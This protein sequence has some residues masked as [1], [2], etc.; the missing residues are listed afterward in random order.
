M[1]FSLLVL[2]ACLIAFCY[3]ANEGTTKKVVATTKKASSSGGGGGHSSGGGGH[4]SGG[5]A[6]S[7]LTQ[8]GDG[9]LTQLCG[10]Q[11]FAS[12]ITHCDSNS[13]SFSRHLL[14]DVIGTIAVSAQCI[15]TNAPQY[16]LQGIGS[17]FGK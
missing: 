4:S 7:Q 10:A 2:L 12:I 6:N 14:A 16:I 11:Q 9:M 5:G 15:G 8:Y 1:K 13:I 17:I 3:A